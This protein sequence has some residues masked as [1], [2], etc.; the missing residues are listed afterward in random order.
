MRAS[1]Y[2]NPGL[3]FA[4]LA[5][6]VASFTLLQSL[7]IPVLT[8]IQQ[9]YDTDQGTVTWVLTA[10]LLSASISTPLLGRVGDAVGKSRILC[11]TLSALML[12]SFMAAIAPSIGWL[13]AARVVQGAGGGVVPL[14]FGIVRDEFGGRVRAA[15]SILSS[16]TA[17]GFGLGIVIA[18]PIVDH[19]GY[20][21]LYWLPML[22]TM[23]AAG[24]TY[25]FIPE[26]PVRTSGRL[27]LVAGLLLAGWLVA[28]LLGLSQGSAWRWTSPKIVGLLGVTVLLG[29]GWVLVE[30]R[31]AVPMID[32]RMM[33]RRGVWT[34]NVVGGFVG[35]AMFASFGFLPQFL[36][37]PASTGYGFGATITESGHVLLPSAIGSFVVALFTA[38]LVTRF[39]VRPVVLTGTVVLG[40]AY[41]G[42]ALWH[43]TTWHLVVTTAAQGTGSGLV[44]SSLAGVIIASVPR[45]QTGVASGM[46]ANIRTIGGSVGS[47]MMAGIVTAH[48]GSTGYPTELGYTIGFLILGL[49]MI[50]AFL[51]ALCIPDN[52]S[53]PT[54]GRSADAELGMVPAAPAPTDDCLDVADPTSKTMS[55]DRDQ[56]RLV[57][58]S[59]RNSTDD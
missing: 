47:A 12:G 17:V 30:N 36:Q 58:S 35:F 40:L 3:T 13:I 25:L 5:I 46:N 9:Q 41:L 59:C 2:Q 32:L 14:A 24:A 54:S 11:L 38:P 34:A 1:R 50:P 33:R 19:L 56:R 43:D 53:Q 7:T 57:E 20:H 10:Y 21:W 22:T 23:T 45:D 26:S 49:A 15:L 8:E 55:L 51:A 31:S 48:V 6:S 42:I 52:R 18:G 29:V 16:L 37:T 39:G 27:P 28:G 4:I 44:F